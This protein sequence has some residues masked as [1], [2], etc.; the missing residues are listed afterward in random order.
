M[1]VC[2]YIYIYIYIYIYGPQVGR[3]VV[4]FTDGNYDDLWLSKSGVFEIKVNLKLSILSLKID[5][6]S[7]DKDNNDKVTIIYGVPI[8]GLGYN[9]TDYN[10]GTH[11]STFSKQP[12]PWLRPVH[13]LFGIIKTIM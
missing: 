7:N 12:L 5:R 9:F 1:Y 4:D 2:M 8:W 11:T 6:S 10:F 3:R 13:Q